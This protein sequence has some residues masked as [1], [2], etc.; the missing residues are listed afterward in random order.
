MISVFSSLGSTRSLERARRFRVDLDGPEVAI[1]SPLDVVALAARIVGSRGAA[2]LWTSSVK[3]LLHLL[4]EI[5]LDEK[6]ERQLIERAARHLESRFGHDPT[7]FELQGSRWEGDWVGE[8]TRCDGRRSVAS[9]EYVAPSTIPKWSWR[10][11]HVGEFQI[12][13]RVHVADGLDAHIVDI[14][15]YRLGGVRV[16]VRGADGEIRQGL[17]P[18]AVAR[19]SQRPATVDFNREHHSFDCAPGPIGGS[20]ASIDGAFLALRHVGCGCDREMMTDDR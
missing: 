7:D 1:D 5:V 10:A 19:A 4:L 16:I 14:V 20:P 8:L 3:W 9:E 17:H 15:S 11:R 18:S 6:A 13:D 12:A 2:A